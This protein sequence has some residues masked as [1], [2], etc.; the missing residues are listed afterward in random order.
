M[1]ALDIVSSSGPL[2]PIARARRLGFTTGGVTSVLDRLER[3]A[4]VR[5]WIDPDDRR[6]QLVEATETAAARNREV[7]SGLIRATKRLLETYTEDQLLA[8]RDFL[9]RT[10]DLT[11]AYADELTR[12]DDSPPATALEST[13]QKTQTRMRQTTSRR[14]GQPPA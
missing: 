4:Y 6:R 9:D 8:I 14:R 2:S 12:R 5:R 1:R 3:T 7:F 10:G 13:T 11:A